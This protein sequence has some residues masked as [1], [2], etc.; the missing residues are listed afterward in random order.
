MTQQ[1]TAYFCAEYGLQVNLPI[2]AGGLGV[3][4]GDTLKAAADLDEPFIAVGLLY[5]GRKARQ[6]VNEDGWQIDL[7]QR[8]DPVEAGLEHVYKDGEPIFVKVYTGDHSVWARVWVKNM[9]S[10]VKLYLLDTDTDQNRPED[11]DINDSLYFGDLRKQFKQQLILGMGGGR[12]LQKLG[13]KPKVYHINEGRPFFLIWELMLQLKQY[14]DYDFKTIEKILNQN[15]VYTNHTLVPAGNYVI[16]RNL[17]E[18]I[19]SYV[20]QNLGIEVDQLLGPGLTDDMQNFSPTRLALYYSH[21]Q[22]GVSQ[23]HTKLSKEIWPHLDWTSVTNGVHLP[24]WQDGRFGQTE[25]SDQELWSIHLDNKK[26]LEQLVL[27]RTGFRYNSDWLTIGWARRLAGYKRLDAIFADLDRLARIVKDQNRP[28]QL[29]V[30]GKAHQED[31]GGKTMLQKVIK[32]MA[33]E[34]SGH[35]LFIPNYE[36]ELAKYMIRGCDVWLN[37]PVRGR[38]ACGTSGMKA[39]SNGVLQCTTRDGW[40]DEVDWTGKGWTLNSDDVS[41]HF[42]DVLQDQIKPLYYQNQ[43]NPAWLEMMRGSIQLADS[44]SAKKMFKQYK[45]LLY[46]E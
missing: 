19:A 30:A 1:P 6:T 9:S 10:Q 5:R 22:S 18:P 16:Q 36:L 11:R 45:K 27:E 42:Y 32:Y 13:F 28:V 37:I 2:Y 17:V 25:L 43:P 15:L 40:T 4:A 33:N 31:D 7:D 20:A 41:Q 39:I 21:K 38:E 44:F 35:A 29:L 26:K 3:L 12:L 24:T 46:Q 14:A 23:L 8:F 34:L